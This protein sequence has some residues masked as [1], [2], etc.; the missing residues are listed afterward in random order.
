M[1][2][3]FLRFYLAY[4]HNSHVSLNQIYHQYLVDNRN[5]PVYLS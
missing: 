1:I 5:M 2:L 4:S 3:Q